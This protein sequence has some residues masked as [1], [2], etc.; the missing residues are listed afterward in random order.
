MDTEIFGEYTVWVL[1]TVA[2]VVLIVVILYYVLRGVLNR[3]KQRNTRRQRR[4][5]VCP[6]CGWQGDAGIHAG[7]CPR[8]DRFLEDRKID[9]ET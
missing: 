2:R 5:A 9:G 4:T 6:H 3:W 1:I 7:R 8:C